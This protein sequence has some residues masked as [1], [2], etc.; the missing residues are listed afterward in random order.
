MIRSTPCRPSAASTPTAS[1]LCALE[2]V[3]HFTANDL[4][5]AYGLLEG[6][7]AVHD[8]VDLLVRISRYE[9]FDWSCRLHRS[10]DPRQDPA[11]FAISANMRWSAARAGC[12][13]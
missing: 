9:G 13:P 12:A 7:Y 8:K 4:E 3:G 5:N 6:A 1:D 2:I 11:R 10:H